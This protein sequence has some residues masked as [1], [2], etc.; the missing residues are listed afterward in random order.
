MVQAEKSCISASHWPTGGSCSPRTSCND[1]QVASARGERQKQRLR[2]RDRLFQVLRCQLKERV[3]IAAHHP[4]A[5][6]GGSEAVQ[7]LGKDA[8]AAQTL[9]VRVHWNV[10]TSCTMSALRV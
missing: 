7:S 9:Q 8:E 10:G 4:G 3:A 5:F 2:G 1:V 6:A